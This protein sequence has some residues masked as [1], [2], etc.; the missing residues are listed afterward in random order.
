M[1]ELTHVDRGIDPTYDAHSCVLVLGSMASPASRELGYNYGH[2][3]NRFWPVL[4][5]C[6]GEPTPET[7][8][9][10]RAFVLRH[11]I[12]LWDVIASC[13]IAGASDTSIKNV[14]PNDLTLVTRQ[15][16]IRAVFC[17]GA[18]AHE[19]YQ[20]WCQTSVGMPATRLPSTSPANAACSFERLVAAYQQIFDAIEA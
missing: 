1:A 7:T 12:A 3:R 2:P 20:R 19:L 10:R 14:V 11:R 5:A 8:E 4:A 18:K 13:D 15:A 9:E 17:T 16:P 6:T